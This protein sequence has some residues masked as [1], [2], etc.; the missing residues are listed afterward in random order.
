MRPTPTNGPTSPGAPIRTLLIDNYDSFTFNL[1]HLLAQVNGRPPTVVP[2]DWPAF[3]PEILTHF[4]NIVISPGPGSPNVPTDIGIAEVVVTQSSIPVLG[5]CLGHQILAH[6]YGGTVERAPEPMHGRTSFIEHINDYLFHSIP[7][8]FSATRYHSLTVTHVPPQLVMTAWTTDGILMGLRHRDL[9]QWGVQF[10]PESIAT[11]HGKQLLANFASATR[12]WRA[13]QAQNQGCGTAQ[14]QSQA[15]ILRQADTTSVMEIPSVTPSDPHPTTFDLHVET[16][17]LT[18]TDAQL[19]TALYSGCDHAF[20]LDGNQQG[21]NN[22]RWSIMGAPDGPHARIARAKAGTVTVTHADGRTHTMVGEF[23]AW[24]ES[25]LAATRV[26]APRLPFDFTLGW[27]GYLGYELKAEVGSP[28][29][30]TSPLA[31][32][33]LMFVDRAVVVD[34]QEGTVYLLALVPQEDGVGEMERAGQEVTRD[35]ATPD[36]ATR[37]AATRA[38]FTSTLD[39]IARAGNTRAAPQ[40]SPHIRTTLTA[41]HSRAEYLNLI[42][43]ARREI[44]RGESYEICL[45][46]MLRGNDLGEGRPD[47]LGTYLR[48]RA[49]NPTP[50][51]AYLHLP[52]AQILSTSPERFLR[53]G[54]DGRVESSPIKGTRP[55]GQTPSEDASL[56]EE[57]RN[58]EKDRAENLMIVDLVRHDLGRTA[59]IGRVQVERLF[60]I[61]S[62]ATVH[63]MVSTVTA[64]LA[65]GVSPVACV[66]AAFPPGSMTGAPKLRTMEI[67]DA[68]EGGPRG[69]YSGAVGYFSLNGAVDLS[70]VIRTLVM[71][72]CALEYGVG[73]AIVAL[74]DPHAEYAETITKARPLTRLV[75]WGSGL[76]AGR[77]DGPGDGGVGG[78]TVGGLKGPGEVVP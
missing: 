20:W 63:Q 28:N 74:S 29:R 64:R 50:F 68:L 77:L 11:E 47:P 5:I 62:Y 27:V 19:F 53:I 45:T 38:W 43:A 25:M 21:A 6:V 18:C 72:G 58:S 52:E 51:G 30:H 16:T 2:N 33:V 55:R 17:P 37:D 73:G 42:H 26:V 24:L 71:C 67:L 56:R 1:Y 69:V 34:H 22:S 10:H 39:Q 46:N 61:K 65:E 41:R 4:D 75:G 59:Q 9:P 70:V 49:D 36:P 23:F 14:Q 8:P 76:D 60:D 32:A 31:D 13:R 35:P 57:L 3:T 44:E 12:D 66:K 7:S 40:P 54:S 15:H 48:L 78:P